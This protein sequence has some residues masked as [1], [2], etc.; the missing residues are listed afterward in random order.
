MLI[1]IT[2]YVTEAYRNNEFK[3]KITSD[4]VG[5]LFSD[6]QVSKEVEVFIKPYY[7]PTDYY[8]EFTPTRESE[9]KKD[10]VKDCIF[11][12]KVLRRGDEIKCSVFIVETEI[13]DTHTAYKINSNRKDVETY[14]DFP[15]WLYPNDD[16]FQRL[17]VDSKE[18]LKFR[19]QWR[20]TCINR[21]KCEEITGSEWNGYRKNRG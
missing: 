18:S 2:G 10:K 20:Y 8:T 7:Y 17:E 1:D 19:K 9:Y 12:S 5:S 3:I 4:R 13:H 14:A 11:L 16:D 15:L 21:K 6:I